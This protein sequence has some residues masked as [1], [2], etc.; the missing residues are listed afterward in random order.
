MTDLAIRSWNNTPISRRTTDGYVNATAM[1]KANGKQWSH[2]RETERAN[3]Y[4]EA[5]SRNTEIRVGVDS[6]DLPE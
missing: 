2:Y 6:P 1:A 3:T 4:I 5:L